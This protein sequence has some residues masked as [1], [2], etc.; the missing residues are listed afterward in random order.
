MIC[1]GM[2]TLC[3]DYR[4]PNVYSRNGY[5]ARD[6]LSWSENKDENHFRCEHC[7]GHKWPDYPIET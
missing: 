6:C 4:P 7:P 1:E 5:C 2:D 3:K